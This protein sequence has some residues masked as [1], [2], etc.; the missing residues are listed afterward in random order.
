MR[1]DDKLSHAEVGYESPS[2]HAPEH[3]WNCANFIA[4]D[5][6]AC[7]HVRKPIRYDDWCRRWKIHAGLS[8]S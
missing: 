6:P 4:S 1:E 3:C 8:R 2:T 5:P 7:K